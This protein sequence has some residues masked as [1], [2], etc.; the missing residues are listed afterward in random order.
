MVDSKLVR[1]RTPVAT[2]GLNKKNNRHLKDAFKGAARTASTGS[3]VFKPHFE[4]LVATGMREALAR[5][6]VARK[7][8]ATSLV[9]WK[10][11]ERFQLGKAVIRTE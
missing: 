7:I 3:G 8:A 1:K 5:L 4:A 6:T 11:G 2:R 10:K 9:I